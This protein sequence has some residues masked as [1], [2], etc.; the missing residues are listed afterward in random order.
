MSWYSS[1]DDRD[2]EVEEPQDLK[3]VGPAT[4]EVFDD[5]DIDPQDVVEK[6]IS[7]R[8]LVDAGV[9]AG[10]A[11]KIRRWHSLSWTF[12]TGD[13]LDRR[14][15]QIRGLEDDERDWVA[16]SYAGRS[17]EASADDEPAWAARARERAESTDAD[18]ADDGVAGDDEFAAEAEWVQASESGAETDGSGDPVEAESAWQ[19]RSTSP[20]VTEIDG[21]GEAYGERL[22]EAGINTV[23]SLAVVNPERVAD[24]TG[25]PQGNLEQWREA[26]RDAE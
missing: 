20:P 17:P 26:A 1:S 6:E 8:M 24:A 12:D 18:A 19:Q 22:A 7:Y 10:V 9:N 14:S 16:A 11:A 23:R 15:Q 21:I 4:A 25:I 5:E 2:V 3:F 13:D